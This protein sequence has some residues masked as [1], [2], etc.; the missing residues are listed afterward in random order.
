LDYSIRSSEEYLD[1]RFLYTAPARLRI[2]ANLKVLPNEMDMAESGINQI[3]LYITNV[4]HKSARFPSLKFTAPP[5][6]IIGNW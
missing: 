5:R 1:Q 2:L 4:L 3:F 6:T